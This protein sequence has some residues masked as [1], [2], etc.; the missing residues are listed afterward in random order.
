MLMNQVW[1][2]VVMVVLNVL[3]QRIQPQQQRPVAADLTQAACQS[4]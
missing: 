4:V 1:N 3:L 2:P